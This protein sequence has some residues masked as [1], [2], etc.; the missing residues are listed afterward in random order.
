MNLT[1]TINGTKR[2]VKLIKLVL[3][4]DQYMKYP[5]IAQACIEY[6]NDE[7]EIVSTYIDGNDLIDETFT[8]LE[9]K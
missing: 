6:K 9:I 3:R 2:K 8:V 1:I 4:K 7:G 5:I